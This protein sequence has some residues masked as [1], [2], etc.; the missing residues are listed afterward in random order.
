MTERLMDDIATSA[1]DL[2]VDPQ[3]HEFDDSAEGVDADGWLVTS[4]HG[5]EN[6]Q[7]SS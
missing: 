5:S 1:D 3:A 7:A 6:D 2:P 4:V